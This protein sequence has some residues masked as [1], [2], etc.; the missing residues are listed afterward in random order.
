[1]QEMVQEMVQRGDAGAPDPVLTELETVQADAV[2]AA[3]AAMDAA[4]AAKTASDA[5]LA[6]RENRAVIQTG[7]LS[8]G[9]SGMLAHAAYM[10]AKAAADAAKDAQDGIRRSSCRVTTVAG[11]DAGSGNG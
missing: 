10:Y 2:T 6:A 11:G 7:D 4:T 8:G 9:N 5:A 1:M 3:T